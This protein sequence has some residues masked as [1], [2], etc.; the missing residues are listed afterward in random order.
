MLTS[1]FAF[2]IV[3]SVLIIFHELG[4]FIVARLF[5]VGVEKFSL[6]FGP[7]LFGKKIGMTDYRI[8]A[9]PLG[10]YVKMV[11]DEPDTE[12]DPA[13]IPFSFTHKNVFKRILI[14][15]AGP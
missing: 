3:L 7:R 2:V 5:G 12:I 13:A 11:G 8:S 14:V 15:A 1:I 9:I 6:G 4:H 10:G